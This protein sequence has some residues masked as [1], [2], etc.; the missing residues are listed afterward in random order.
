M[1]GGGRL[2]GALRYRI[3]GPLRPVIAC[4]CTR[5][6]KT[7]DDHV[8]APQRRAGVCRSLPIRRTAIRGVRPAGHIRCAGK[9]AYHDIA[10]GLP[11]AAGADPE[12]TAA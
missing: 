5:R 7:S 2:C 11:R 9:G 8:A 12:M 6:R 4:H 1:S 10:D 3:D